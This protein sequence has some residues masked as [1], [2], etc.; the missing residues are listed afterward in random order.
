MKTA[1]QII[2][3]GIETTLTA[4]EPT[5]I[6]ENKI[7]YMLASASRLCSVALGGTLDPLLEAIKAGSIRESPYVG[8]NN[9]KS[10]RITTISHLAKE[11]IKNNVCS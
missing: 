9:P 2:T 3:M 1:K 11:L 10:A 8:C 7:G 4:I 6:P 5:N